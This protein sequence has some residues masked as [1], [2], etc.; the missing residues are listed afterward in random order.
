VKWKSKIAPVFDNLYNLSCAN[1][2]FDPSWAGTLIGH[3]GVKD[4]PDILENT[5]EAFQE[6]ASRGAGIVADIGEDV[7]F[8]WLLLFAQNIC[9]WPLG[10]RIL[11]SACICNQIH[12]PLEV[13][14]VSG[15]P[16]KLSNEWLCC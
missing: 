10:C 2:D 1:S 3:R 15:T 14:G 7:T 11:V 6:A 9:S 12:W 13:S 5:L 8:C 16:P 4:H